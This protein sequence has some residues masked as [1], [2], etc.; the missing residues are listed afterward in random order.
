LEKEKLNY[1]FRYYLVTKWTLIGAAF[2]AL[3]IITL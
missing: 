3:F 2:A 1:S